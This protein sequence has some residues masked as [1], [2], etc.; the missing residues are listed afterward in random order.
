[1][2][3][4][5]NLARSANPTCGNSFLVPQLTEFVLASRAESKRLWTFAALSWK[6]TIG[7]DDQESSM[8]QAS[9]GA[10]RIA[11]ALVVG[12]LVVDQTALA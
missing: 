10:A 5:C 8:N 4:L 6:R 11:V 2:A 12:L 9:I 7:A 3:Y 1:V